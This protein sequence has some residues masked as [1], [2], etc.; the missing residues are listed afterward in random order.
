MISCVVEHW[1]H[2]LAD[3]A[4]EGTSSHGVDFSQGIYEQYVCLDG[5]RAACLFDRGVH[6]FSVIIL[7]SNGSVWQG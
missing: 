4:M 7:V 1:L 2:A 6:D 3:D 5:E